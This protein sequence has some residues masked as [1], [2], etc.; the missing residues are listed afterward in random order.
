[1]RCHRN[2]T[3]VL[4]LASLL[5][6]GFHGTLQGTL[7]GMEL[8]GCLLE[9]EACHKLLQ[10]GGVLILLSNGKKAAGLEKKMK[11]EERIGNNICII[12]RS[13]SSNVGWVML[14][15]NQKTTFL[16]VSTKYPQLLLIKRRG[17]TRR[18]REKERREKERV[19]EERV[20]EEGVGEERVGEERRGELES[21]E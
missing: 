11:S 3:H 21:R 14:E 10:M 18:R 17:E 12:S 13:R 20:G 8:I 9:Q 16:V 19:G 4:L 6:G 1:M 7:Q 15:D 2:V 5:G